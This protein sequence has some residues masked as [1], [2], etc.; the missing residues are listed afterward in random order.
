MDRAYFIWHS[1]LFHCAKGLLHRAKALL[2]R[3]KGLLHHAKAL[4]KCAKGLFDFDI[5]L[6][7]HVRYQLD[8]IH[9]IDLKAFNCL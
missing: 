5:A 7:Q 1:A 9:L 3:A 8:A 4:L 2:H 6:S